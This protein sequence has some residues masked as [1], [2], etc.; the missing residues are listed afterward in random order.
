M[1]NIKSAIK[2]VAVNE[3]KRV[4]NKMRKSS[5]RTVV[6]KADVAISEGASDAAA[7]VRDA[8]RKI[9]KACAKGIMHK[10]TAARQK[11]RLANRLAK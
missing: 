5:L 7:L 3:R 10:N 9:D 1:P 4:V 2:R 6:K 11:S 8:Q